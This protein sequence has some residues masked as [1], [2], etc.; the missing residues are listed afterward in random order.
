FAVQPVSPCDRLRTPCTY[1][2]VEDRTDKRSKDRTD[3]PVSNRT[4]KREADRT[5]KPVPDRT[6]RPVQDRTGTRQ[7]GATGGGQTRPPRR[8]HARGFLLVSAAG[9]R[10]GACGDRPWARRT[11]SRRTSERA[12]ERG[13]TR[14]RHR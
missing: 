7:T 8:Q 9:A 2:T 4:D 11:R 1:K 3:K 14:P 5:D 6:D 10:R 12:V 13:G